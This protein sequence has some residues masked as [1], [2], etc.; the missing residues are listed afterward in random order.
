MGTDAGPMGTDAGPMGTDAGAAVCMADGDCTTGH[1]NH[2]YSFCLALGRCE[3]LPTDCSTAPLSPVCGCDGATY[4]NHCERQIAGVGLDYTGPCDP[5]GACTIL[6][7]RNCCYDNE[8]CSERGYPPVPFARA[9]YDA[10]SCGSGGLGTCRQVPGTGQCWSNAE[11][12]GS[13]TCVGARSCTC[14]EISA[15]TCASVTLGRC[16]AP[17]P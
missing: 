12:A 9:C 2:R 1:C 3:T 6:T 17:T 7:R 8:D 11:C 16:T 5:P 10:G 15:G 4:D 13:E 14:A